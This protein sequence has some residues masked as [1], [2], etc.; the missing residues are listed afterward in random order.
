MVAG[1]DPRGTTSKE[2]ILLAAAELFAEKGYHGTGVAE[3]GDA[4]GLGR[5]ALYHHIG[6]KQQ[7][8]FEVCKQHVDELI[9]DG[10]LLM[11]EE[12]PADAKLRA[13]ARMQMRLIVDHLP[14]VTVFF[15]EMHALTGD[16]REELLRIR[17]EAED[18]WRHVIQQ[19]VDEG[20]FAS[21]DWLTVKG[22]LNLYNYSYVWIDPHGAVSA[23]EIADRLSDIAVGG[24][25][26]ASAPRA[27]AAHEDR[28]GARRLW[29]GRR[30]R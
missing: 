22:V 27:Q 16:R 7:L 18:L 5:G 28:D 14:E 4:V 1:T 25:A 10:R 3:L 9:A 2:R 20:R 17:R 6:S 11:A 12:I 13:L 29:R 30:K 23:E 15:R 8:L 19:G 24:L 21:A 26:R